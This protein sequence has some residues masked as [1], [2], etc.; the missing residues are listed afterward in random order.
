[1]TRYELTSFDSKKISVVEWG[2]ENPVG[3]I[4]ISHGM[5]EHALRYDRF[6]KAMNM[7]G[8]LVVAD[9]HRAHGKTD[10]EIP[11][12]SDG[13]IF[14]DTLKDMAM[15][16]KKYGEDYPNLKKILFGHSYGSF[17]SQ[18]FI[19]EYHT[20]IDGAILGGSAN[21][22]GILPVAGGVVASIGGFFKG[23]NKP[24]KFINHITF[25]NYNKQLGGKSFISSIEEECLRY[26][27][28]PDCGYIC[29][30]AFYKY[31]FNGL[32]Q[33][34]KAKNIEKLN[35]DLPMLII[36]GAKDPVGEFSK[37]TTKLY[38]MYKACGVK[39][40]TLKLYDGVYHEYL[41]DTS[42][43]EATNDILTFANKIISA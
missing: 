41:N 38:E 20:Y 14:N 10:P 43:E 15:I 13:D 34:Y 33:I 4:L 17:L 36:S 8:Y 3:I 18:R 39:D 35:R 27:E 32:K 29:S 24:A 7:A 16:L 30:N 5:C 6:A 21:M 1:M 42:K 2:V 23:K 40:V 37:S 28:D 31:F 22:K 25:D 12:Y 26:N 19:E 9:D 11:G